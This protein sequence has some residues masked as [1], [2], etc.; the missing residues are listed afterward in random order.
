[1]IARDSREKNVCATLKLILFFY[2]AKYIDIE[3]NESVKSVMPRVNEYMCKYIC[4]F[5]IN[6]I[7]FQEKL[8]SVSLKT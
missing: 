2:L 3:C 6:N 4:N 5:N 8:W 1:M 7:I